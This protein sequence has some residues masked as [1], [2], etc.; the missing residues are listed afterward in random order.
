MHP[1]AAQ[2]QDVLGFTAPRPKAPFEYTNTWGNV[3]GLLVV[4]FAV[5]A[6]RARGRGRVFA[7]I[8][9]GV[10][11]VPIV[12]SLNRGLWVGLGLGLLLLAMPAGDERQGWPR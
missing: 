6:V 9:L 8:V 7:V 1:A 10:A 11:L 5:W 4:W 2:I 12:D 3:I